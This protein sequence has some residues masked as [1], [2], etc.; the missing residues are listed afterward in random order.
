[1]DLL[2]LENSVLCLDIKTLGPVFGRP[3]TLMRRQSIQRAA[4]TNQ[5]RHACQVIIK[6]TYSLKDT[7]ESPVKR[8]GALHRSRSLMSTNNIPVLAPR[9]GDRQR[10][11]Q[12]M[13]DVWTKDRLPFP[14]MTG[15]RGG[16][17]IRTSATSVMRKIS[18]ASTTNPANSIRR[19]TVTSGSPMESK[20]E[21]THFTGLHTHQTDGASSPT[22][23][24]AHSYPKTFSSTMEYQDPNPYS[25]SIS[26]TPKRGIDNEACS[27]N[28]ICGSRSRSYHISQALTVV[29]S[30]DSKELEHDG[31]K[32][33]KPRLLFKA[34]STESIRGW[35]H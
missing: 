1:M 7:C 5:R 4:T 32:P 3:G 18:I 21:Q 14:G 13:F 15:H 25:D 20:T 19:R 30:R 29:A 8:S 27:E 35:L 16:H 34:F 33:S 6:N 22:P 23:E 11:E 26:S 10:M 24:N 12:K 31:G 9:R 17:L 2:S 28:V